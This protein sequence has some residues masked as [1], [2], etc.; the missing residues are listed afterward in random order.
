MLVIKYLFI[1]LFSF[2]EKYLKLIKM[3]VKRKILVSDL[4]MWR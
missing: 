3:D 4:G 1:L 2:F